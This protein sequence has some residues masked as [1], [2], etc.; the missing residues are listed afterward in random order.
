MNSAIVTNDGNLL[1]FGNWN[2]DERPYHTAGIASNVS[3]LSL[4]LQI[5]ESCILKLDDNTLF[6]IGG[7]Q[8]STQKYTDQGRPSICE[9][10]PTFNST[11]FYDLNN[12]TYTEGPD[13][14]IERRN[15][16]CSL[17]KHRGKN[18]VMVVGGLSIFGRGQYG[19][20]L[21]SVEM[22]DLSNPLAWFPGNSN[23][24]TLTY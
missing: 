22:L 10:G 17:F 1:A 13:L 14:L 3:I 19:K 18:I 20:L 12:M 16:E 21:H 2:S 4:D 15:H 24:L 9:K 11:Y 6:L 5:A 8:K 7:R 23:S